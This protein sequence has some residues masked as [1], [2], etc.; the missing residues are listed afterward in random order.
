M[1]EDMALQTKVLHAADQLN[2]THAV[3]APIWQTT[4]FSGDS[5]EQLAELKKLSK[6][7]RVPDWSELVRSSEEAEMRIRDLKLK[8]RIE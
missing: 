7:A 3:T 1:S 4:T 6:E 8:A 2:E 5:P